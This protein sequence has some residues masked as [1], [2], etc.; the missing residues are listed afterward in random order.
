MGELE[1]KNKSIPKGTSERNVTKQNE[2]KNFVVK[3]A[4]SIVALVVNSQKVPS[5]IVPVVRPS[6]LLILR[7]HEQWGSPPSG[8][9]PGV[10][11]QT[12]KAM[13]SLIH[14]WSP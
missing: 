2:A 3:E 13:S 14:P 8:I 7:P 5:R 1:S 4:A 10:T 12:R 11:L 6:L 9:L